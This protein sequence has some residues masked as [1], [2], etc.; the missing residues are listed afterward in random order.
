[1]CH[2]VTVQHKLPDTQ[3][4]SH[5]MTQYWEATP[6][7]Y[8]FIHLHYTVRII[9]IIIIQYAAQFV[10][11]S[12]MICYGNYFIH[13]KLINRRRMNTEKSEGS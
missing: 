7:D 4:L 9:I 5:I 2:S 6:E 11:L 8:Q 13:T 12:T 10:Y 1:L 3:W